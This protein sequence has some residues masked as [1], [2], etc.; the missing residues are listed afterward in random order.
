[1]HH[2]V[3]IAVVAGLGGMFGW[4]LADFF[5][6][7]TI[8]Q[9][10]YVVSLVWAHGF[11]TMFF[12]LIA[13]LDWFVRGETHVAPNMQTLGLLAVFGALQ[14]LI[15]FLVYRG[16]EKGQLALLNPVFASFSGVTALLSIALFGEVTTAGRAGGLVVIFAGIVLISFDV[17]ALRSGRV[18]FTR[19]PGLKEIALATLLA[20]FWTLFWGRAVAG[21]DWLSY[22]VIMYAFMT[23]AMVVGAKLTRA[24][25][26]IRGKA[27]WTLLLLVGL[28]ETAA[29]LAI[30]LGYSYTRLI[31][32]VAL[33]SGAFSLPT[34]ILAR[35][36]LKERTTV[37]QA[38][39][40]FTIV[41]GTV[42]L[43]LQ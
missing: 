2:D 41:L 37:A 33:L 25:L 14:A 29:Y 39:G 22:A 40:G 7:K 23:I 36:F 27:P 15:Y 16:F 1:M 34:I 21:N 42:L 19:V 32:V 35:A 26:R 17:E 13:V 30:S 18:R 5:A 6:K 10:G 4:G 20:A 28:C 3:A 8:G 24:D 43:P 31:S 38:V 12:V 11:G 9:V